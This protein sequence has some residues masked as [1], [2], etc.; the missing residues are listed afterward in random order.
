MNYLKNTY[1]YFCT[2]IG[3]FASSMANLYAQELRFDE[4]LLEKFKD[5]SDYDYSEYVPTEGIFSRFMNWLGRLYDQLIR[6]IFGEYDAGSFL[7][8]IIKILPYLIVAGVLILIIYLFVKYNWGARFFGEEKEEASVTFSDEEEIIRNKD[9]DALIEKA[10]AKHNYR[11]A[12][13]YQYLKCLRILDKE[14]KII[15]EFSKTNQDYVDEIKHYPYADLFGKITYYY[16]YA[17]YGGFDVSLSQYQQVEVNF[18]SFVQQ[19][20][21]ANHE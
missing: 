7:G 3:F 18:R 21:I 13:R 20:K 15:Y 16:D 10:L 14:N 11:L 5:D 8:F 12:I 2:S 9:I 17:W 1:T 19:F 4:D 6:A